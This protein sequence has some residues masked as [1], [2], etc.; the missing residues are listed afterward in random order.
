VTYLKLCRQYSKSL[1]LIILKKWNLGGQYS[2]VIEKSGV[3][4]SGT[5]NSYTPH[6]LTDIVNLAL[7][8]GVAL[9][10][11]NNTLPDLDSLDMYKK[12][13]AALKHCNEKGLLRLVT[14]HTTDIAKASKVLH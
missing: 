3:W 5:S 4:T 1:G 13:P 10:R 6:E 2:E 7:Y 12:L 14:D 11:P 9:F 8:H